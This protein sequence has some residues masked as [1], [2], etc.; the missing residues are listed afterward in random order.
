MKICF[1]V[2][3]LMSELKTKLS[4][5]SLLVCDCLWPLSQGGGYTLTCLCVA[6]RNL[7]ECLNLITPFSIG[8]VT[9]LQ[10]VVIFS[11]LKLATVFGIICLNYAKCF[12]FLYLVIVEH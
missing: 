6:S 2:F 4:K 12:F 1:F 3:G 9:I 8:P 5:L 7:S 10:T 11:C